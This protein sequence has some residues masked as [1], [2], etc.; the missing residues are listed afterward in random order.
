MMEET[1]MEESPSIWLTDFNLLKV[2]EFKIGNVVVP[3]E[4]FDSVNP[5]MLENLPVKIQLSNGAEYVLGYTTN[6][7]REGDWFVGDIRLFFKLQCELIMREKIEKIVGIRLDVG[8][9][10]KNGQEKQA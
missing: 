10:I 2:Q 1:S 6:V 5:S 8:R 7:R 3:R 9:T 4:A